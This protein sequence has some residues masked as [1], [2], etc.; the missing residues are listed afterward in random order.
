MQK[1]WK[2]VKEDK[3]SSSVIKQSQ[4]HLVTPQELWIV[5]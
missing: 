4:G 1:Q 5:F 2:R 3:N